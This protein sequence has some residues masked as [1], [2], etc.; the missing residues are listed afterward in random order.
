MRVP[1]FLPDTQVVREDLALH[2]DAITRLDADCGRVLDLLEK[3]GLTDN[4]LVVFFGDNGMPFPRAKASLYQPGVNVPLLVKWPGH[5]RPG[6]VS[7]EL[8]SM[9]D[10]PATW[11]D[12]AGAEKIP[13]AEGRSLTGL[14]EG[15][16]H[17]PRRYVFTERNWHDTW[18]PTRGI[19]SERYS[20][21]ANFRPEV[22]YRGT[23]DHIWASWSR[24][25]GPSWDEIVKERKAGRLK[26]ELEHL[27]R[28]PRPLFELYDLQNDPNEFRNLAGSQEAASALEE[29]QKALTAWMEETNDFLPPVWRNFMS[30]AGPPP[31][32]ERLLNG[33]LPLGD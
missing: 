15:A 24:G 16:P 23:L 28:K 14:L 33:Y 27:F 26:P 1:A 2:Y 30:N 17:E 20:L 13:R 9:V 19:V 7:Q 29:L 12:V 31:G 11:L 4:T 10:L 22:P 5:V 3:R 21:I 32:L 25:G 6:T 18:E 8:V